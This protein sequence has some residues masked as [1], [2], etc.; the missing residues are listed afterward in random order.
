MEKRSREGEV[1]SPKHLQKKTIVKN[2]LL[3][4]SKTTVHLF[5]IEY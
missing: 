4:Y 2:V 3:V 5:Y 1:R